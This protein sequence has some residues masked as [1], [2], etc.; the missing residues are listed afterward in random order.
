MDRRSKLPLP[1]VRVL[2]WAAFV[3][4][5]LL[6]PVVFGGNQYYMYLAS[7]M[8][9][10][11]IVIMG[12][13]L[14]LGYTG[15]ISLGHAA[16]MAIGAY[17]VA[18]MT[19]A[20]YSFWLALPL[21][22][23]IS[24][25]GGL[26]L[27]LPSLRVKHHYLALVTLGFGTVVYLLL[28]NEHEITGGFSGLAGIP[29]P[30]FFGVSLA[31]PVAFY[32]LTAGILTVMTALLLWILNSHWGR[33]FKAI[34]E[35]DVRAEMVGVSLLAYQLLAFAIGAAYAGIG[36]GLIA[37][38]IRYV[39]PTAFPVHESFWFLIM[40]IIG[41]SGRFEGPFIGV[42]AVTLLPELL[43]GVQQMFFVIFAAITLLLLVFW[44]TGLAG[45]YDA[46]FRRV[47]KRTPPQL[48]K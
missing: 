24:F 2:R 37:P 45:L 10:H 39:D 38:L 22:A 4:I 15:Q 32:L 26:V 1:L 29:R 13:N 41:G 27:G 20:G 8:C 23:L 33:A 17:T 18:L 5:L 7:L 35:N 42:I 31:S 19:L 16:F 30:S 21:G 40:L 11:T 3:G 12:L 46:F 9:V 6:V 28:A 14:T 47:L 34:R 43:R 48:T 36:G 25:F 44:P